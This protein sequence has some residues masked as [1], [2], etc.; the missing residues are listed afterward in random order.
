MVP[1]G[2]KVERALAWP[3]SY[4]GGVTPTR[5]A[6][7]IP[8]RQG[9]IAIAA[10]RFANANT[11]TYLSTPCNYSVAGTYPTAS[12][13]VVKRTVCFVNSNGATCFA[14]VLAHCGQNE[15]RLCMSPK[16]VNVTRC[17][18]FLL[19]QLPFPTDTNHN[20]ECSYGWC[21]ADSR[22]EM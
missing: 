14:G 10:I 19:W 13:D 1:H 18:G 6:M 15:C 9:D 20:F 3:Y 4:W 21:G 11:N 2:A 7:P 12:D 5:E 8:L 22:G 16:I 17:A